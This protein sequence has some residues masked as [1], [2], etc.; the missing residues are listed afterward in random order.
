MRKLFAI[1]MAVAAT[2]AMEAATG[3]SD[4]LRN[5]V[6]EVVVTGTRHATDLR[7]LPLTVSVIGREALTANHRMS[8]LTTVTEQ[9][10]GMFVTTRGLMG[11]GVS[12]GAAGTMKIRGVGGGA[13]MLVLIDGQPQ[14]AGLYGHPIAD[15]CQTM[16][17]ERVE[18]VRGPASLL[19]G[20]NAMGGVM[21]IVT[22]RMDNDG[23]STDVRLGGG[24]YGTVEGEIANR[25]R[26][27]R[28]YST[29][30][31]SYGRT[32]GHRLN[33][34][35]EQYSG[36]AKLGYDLGTHWTAN[37]DIYITHFK[38][39]NPG[40]TDAPMTDNDMTVTRGTASVALANN[41]A[42]TSGA[43]RVY[44]NWGHHN[45]DDG[46]KEGATPRTSLYL[47]DDLMAGVSLYQSVALFEGNRLTLGADL[48]HFGGQAWNRPKAGGE[49]T[50]LA[51]KTE[52]EMAVYA[53]FR[54][55]LTAW[56]T[57]DAGIRLDHHSASGTEWVPQG[58]LT[59][60]LSQADELRAM[61]S[62]GFRNPTIKEMYM[63]NPK[64]PLLKPESMVNHEIAYTRRLMNGRMRLGLSAFYLRAKNLISTVRIDGKPLNINTGGT[65]NSGAEVEM[66]FKA[67]PQLNVEANYSYLHTSAH[68]TCAP[69][70]KLYAGADFTTGR[71]ELN[72]GLMYFARLMTDENSDA[73]SHA[74]LL[75]VT[76]TWKAAAGLKLYVRGDNLLAQR[77]ETY[78]G[79]PM[80]RTTFNGGVKWNF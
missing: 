39:S 14:Y 3:P 24:S 45:I 19:Y 66:A 32:D 77:Y 43:L 12:T 75:H 27:G 74:A 13:A 49:S 67:T 33:S 58:G 30:G 71:L 65:E 18:V 21:N 68:I 6:D 41:Y 52:N 23:V 56:L 4:T 31:V 40:T 42:K 11:Y 60:R 48:Q 22:R 69:R 20:S 2:D 73:R 61:V 25:T 72:A 44:Y 17:A 50:S 62:K 8:V 70:H 80:P 15:G 7:H 78:K 36:F 34:S 10:P 35:F 51:D 59:A 16:T 47:H 64:N 28:L 9:V 1:L 53:D 38:N 54:Q 46:Y 57:I 26:C 76:A 63:F 55:D 79:F 29:A 5:T 37:G